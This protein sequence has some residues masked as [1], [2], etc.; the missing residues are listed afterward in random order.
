MKEVLLW[1]VRIVVMNWYCLWIVFTTCIRIDN[2]ALLLRN[3][4]GRWFK[5]F[6]SN[7]I[8]YMRWMMLRLTPSRIAMMVFLLMIGEGMIEG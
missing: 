5:L 6:L 4:V 2:L 7:R 8:M 1:F 3:V